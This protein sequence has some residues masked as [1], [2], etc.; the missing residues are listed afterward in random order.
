MASDRRS[1]ISFLQWRP[2]PEALLAAGDAINFVPASLDEYELL[3][4]RSASGKLSMTP[5]GEMIE[6][7]T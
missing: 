3:S 4:A 6:E 1:P 5:V 7:A 2:H